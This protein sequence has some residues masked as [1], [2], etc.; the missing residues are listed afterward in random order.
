[1]TLLPARTPLFLTKEEVA[2]ILRIGERQ[3][4]KLSAQ[5][6]LNKLKLS[7]RRVGF[8]RD[9][10]EVYLQWKVTGVSIRASIP[11]QSL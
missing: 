6:D 2:T 7:G 8:H 4:D 10:I 3:I 11:A 1:M 9:A 5:G